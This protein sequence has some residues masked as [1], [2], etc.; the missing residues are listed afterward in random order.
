MLPASAPGGLGP[1]LQAASFLV[2]HTFKN[3]QWAHSANLQCVLVLPGRVLGLLHIAGR[4]TQATYEQGKWAL[5]Q[6]KLAN[7]KRQGSGKGEAFLEDTQS[8]LPHCRQDK[9]VKHGSTPVATP[10]RSFP[11][12]PLAA[13]SKPS[14]RACPTRSLWT[15]TLSDTSLLPPLRPPGLAA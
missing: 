8:V 14:S 15:Q 7:P 5:N 10:L 6:S 11:N 12:S 3:K 2:T 13:A 4:T 9:S 1:D